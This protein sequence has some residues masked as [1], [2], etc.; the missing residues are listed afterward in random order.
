[1]YIN[2]TVEE[3]KTY[4]Y[5]DFPYGS[6][7][8]ENLTDQD[9]TRAISEITLKIND[10]LF[11]SQEEYTYAA[12]YFTAHTVCMNIQ[13]S[14]QGLNSKFDWAYSSKS[15]GSISVGQSLPPE[16]MANPIYAHYGKTAYGVEYLNFI[17]PRTYGA[18]GIATGATTA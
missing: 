8:N 17:L 18:I 9:I 12:L 14:S 11:C 5:R 4:F 13:Q 2:P 3:F 15:V 16:V 6:D 10:Q 1:M 7:I